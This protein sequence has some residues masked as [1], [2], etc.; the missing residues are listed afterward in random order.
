MEDKKTADFRV[1]EKFTTRAFELL[2]ELHALQFAEGF[3]LGD[4]LSHSYAREFKRIE[5]KYGKDHPLMVTPYREIGNSF[6][7]QGFESPRGASALNS[8]LELL[9]EQ[10][11]PDQLAVRPERPLPVFAPSPGASAGCRAVTYYPVGMAQGRPWLN[12]ARP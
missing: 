5:G 10:P 7:S 11:D 1:T 2:D 8:A 9:E 4:A 12:M 6:R 3:R